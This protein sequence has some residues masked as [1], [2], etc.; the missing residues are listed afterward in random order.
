[1]QLSDES[2][3]KIIKKK[4]G[5]A[6]R[7]S[8]DGCASLEIRQDHH[9]RL[10][11]Q[12][13]PSSKE[14]NTKRRTDKQKTVENRRGNEKK[15]KKTTEEREKKSNSSEAGGQSDMTESQKKKNKCK[16][17]NNRRKKKEKM[18]KGRKVGS[19][20]F[21]SMNELKEGTRITRRAKEIDRN[22]CLI[23]LISD[24]TA[25]NLV[26][27]IKEEQTTTY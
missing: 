9:A 1:M 23:V 18:E 13:R 15:K 25:R 2:G 5:R 20:P 3:K 21:V 22:T 4:L 24:A 6:V 27:T 7:A 10:N 19:F 12:G 8:N 17:C 14:R 26:N 16:I 11:S